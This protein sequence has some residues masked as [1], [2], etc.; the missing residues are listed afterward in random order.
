VLYFDRHG[1]YYATQ[2]GQMTLSS[3][4]W[5]V[6]RMSILVPSFNAIDLKL[7]A[8]FGVVLLIGT[9]ATC[10]SRRN[11]ERKLVFSDALLIAAGGQFVLYVFAPQHVGGGGF[12]ND[13]IFLFA[14]VTFALWIAIQQYSRVTIAVIASVAIVITLG[15]QAR[16]FKRN[17]WLSAMLDEYG[18][19][20]SYIDERKSLWAF[21]LDPAGSG[22]ANLEE[23]GLRRDPFEHAGAMLALQRNLVDLNNYETAS[24]NFP[25]VYKESFDPTR[26]IEKLPRNGGPPT[27]PPLV[28]IAQYS[29]TTGRSVDY[30]L[31]W[32]MQAQNHTNPAIKN[33]QQQIS[34]EYV[35]IY[36]AQKIPLLLYRLR[37]EGS[38]V[39]A[40]ANCPLASAQ[41]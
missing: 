12:I 34:S 18:T 15:L 27:F 3:L 41:N 28:N 22:Y 39:R 1:K 25:I 30:V 4:S 35:L 37:E 20:A 33:L 26:I 13:R 17:A 9:V 5:S 7:S 29:R 32:D 36:C 2:A 6:T 10:F 21:D 24:R 23:N 11:Q 19:A 16:S 14:L 38:S 40:D 8:L 31:L